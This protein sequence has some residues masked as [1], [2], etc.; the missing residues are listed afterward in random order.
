MHTEMLY[1]YISIDC[2]TV[3]VV[4]AA[5]VFISWKTIPSVSWTMRIPLASADFSAAG[6]FAP[7]PPKT[8]NKITINQIHVCETLF[9]LMAVMILNDVEQLS[10][11][12]KDKINTTCPDHVIHGNGTLA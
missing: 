4:Q 9:M 2:S 5:I 11:S 8:T 3:R 12:Q 10:H 6:K 1:L 7:A